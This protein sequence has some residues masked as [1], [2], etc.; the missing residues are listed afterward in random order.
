MSLDML[1]LSEIPEAEK[2]TFLEKCIDK[3][4]ENSSVSTIKLS[5]YLVGSLHSSAFKLFAIV[6]KNVENICISKDYSDVDP[7]L[8]KLINKNCAKIEESLRSRFLSDKESLDFDWKASL[9]LESSKISNLNNTLA[10]LSFYVK[11]SPA[12]VAECNEEELEILIQELENAKSSAL[13]V[14]S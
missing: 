3:I 6:L 13:S 12:I 14:T 9:V 7:D 5:N 11:D 10:M 4:C 1:S 8:L 2:N